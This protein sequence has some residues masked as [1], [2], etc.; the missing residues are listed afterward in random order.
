MSRNAPAAANRN[1]SVP[2][3][4][5]DAVCFGEDAA[6]RL[7][8]GNGERRA[9][10]RRARAQHRAD[11]RA[12]DEAQAVEQFAV[13]ERRGNRL[14][15]ELHPVRAGG[16]VHVDVS[17]AADEVVQHAIDLRVGAETALL[18]DVSE[19][20]AGAVAHDCRQPH[21]RLA[22]GC[23]VNAAGQ[24]RVAHP[25]RRAK[26]AVAKSAC[27]GTDNLRQISNYAAVRRP[28]LRRR[29]RCW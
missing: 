12:L 6:Q 15:C 25:G 5:S 11:I 2:R 1:A 21:G 29:V 3:I 13:S 24:K 7:F 28:E 26:Q 18:H 4:R 9:E 17:I 19:A 10:D 8:D 27:F 20:I 16:V 23:D 14:A 22:A